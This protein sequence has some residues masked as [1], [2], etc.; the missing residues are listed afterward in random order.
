[1][2]VNFLDLNKQIKSI[3]K[4]ILNSIKKNIS[5]S[6][7]IGGE[8]LSR[9]QKN[10]SEYLNVKYCLGVANGT[11]ALEIAI[12][13]L[14]LK[15]KSEIIVPANTWISTA[16]SV[17]NNNYKL[18]FVDVDETHNIC[19]KDLQKK[20]S[21]KTSAI[22][23]VHLFG[24]PANII[25][26]KQ[27]SSKFSIKIIEDCAQSHGAELNGKKTSSFG[28]ISTFSFFPS[29]NLGCFGDGGCIVTNKKNLFLKAKK[30][31]NHGGLKK[32]S[33]KIIG[34]NSRLDNIQAG[35]LNIKLS[36]LDKWIGLREKQAK[37]YKYNLNGT[38]DIRF[39]KQIENSKSSNHL[40]VIKTNKRNELRKYLLKN[41]IHT[42]IHYPLALPQMPV[43]KNKHKLYCNNMN[44][45]KWSKNIISLPIGEHMNE[46]KLRK[47]CSSI[48]S[49]FNA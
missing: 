11:D 4:K 13:C 2:I 36:Y 7:Y 19:I 35:I 27:I 43:F 9:F 14:G 3:D 40:F 34:R 28:D 49:F 12:K 33:H 47:V 30:I 18:K 15:K 29:K 26:I 39:I 25:K 42:A 8:D 21:N 37:F 44:A 32:N 20:I 6:S 1:M 24:N 10:F 45:V 17:I 41:K 16:E 22:I 38:G 23:I 46:I 48:K 31:A 5:K